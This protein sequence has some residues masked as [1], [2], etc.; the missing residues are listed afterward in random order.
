MDL[1][2]KD[3]VSYVSKRRGLRLDCY[4]ES[5][6][7][8]RIELRMR[9]LGIKDFSEYLGYIKNNGTEIDELLNTIAINVTE[10]MRDKTP[11]DFLKQKILPE[12]AIRKKGFI[13][14]WS[15]GCASGE[16]AYSIAISVLETLPNSSFSIYA[17]DI[18]EDSLKKA[19]SGVYRKEQLKNLSPYLV[20]KYFEKIEEG[21]KVKDVLRKNIRFKKHDL[22]SQPPITKYLDVIFCRNVL[23]Y[24]T[25]EQKEKVLGDFY[26][27]LNSGGYL[28][29]G[30]CESI[31]KKGFQ[32]VNLSD[33]IYRKV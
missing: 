4:R 10:F 26:E 12:L 6:L 33:K 3:I 27:A 20:G 30:K 14:F 11:F 17:T 25:E 28:V 13:R 19:I 18:D 9:Y 15:A 31:T 21:F 2:L 24:F 29:I 7:R 8:R 23:I 32:C 16:E 22:T 1:I 5:Y